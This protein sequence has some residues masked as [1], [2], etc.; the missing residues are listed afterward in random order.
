MSHDPPTPLSP[1]PSSAGMGCRCAPDWHG[2]A[3]KRKRV[4]KE[5]LGLGLGAVS[6]CAALPCPAGAMPIDAGVYAT[7]QATGAFDAMDLG[8]DEV[9]RPAPH[10]LPLPA[11]HS[12]PP[13]LTHSL[14][15]S[16]SPSLPLT[17]CP[18]RP[19]ALC[20]FAASPGLGARWELNS[21]LEPA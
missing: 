8:T 19:P 20:L 13:S 4:F 16:L 14:S 21:R 7:L 11:S 15:P 2:M 10:S 1:C 9:T 18:S 6:C 17:L 5:S 3:W 12:L